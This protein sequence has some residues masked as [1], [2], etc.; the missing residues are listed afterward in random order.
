MY[1]IRQL[2]IDWEHGSDF[3]INRPKGCDCYVLVFVKTKAIFTLNG[4]D[5]VCE[6]N[7]FALYNI[8]T[9]H[10]YRTYGDY[11][12]NDW[13]QFDADE[14]VN[15]PLDRLIYVGDAVNISGYMNLIADAF[16]S[17]NDLAYSLLLSA[18]FAQ[19]LV[20]SGEKDLYSTYSAKFLELR[21]DIYAY[22]ERNWTVRD[23][24][25]RIHVGTTY[26]QKL[27]RKSFGVSCGADIINAR[28]SMAKYLLVESKLTV[29][30]VGERCGYNSSVHFSRQFKQV[31]GLSPTDYRKQYK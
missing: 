8:N 12:N 28:T 18:M 30:E 29:S 25:D 5:V 24:A 9:P 22:P 4:K 16:Y 14:R 6:P 10:F 15:A 7:T 19:I 11:F 2:G 21:K 31:T 27:Y 3:S 26:F 20:I 13:I 17:K 23:M 1:H